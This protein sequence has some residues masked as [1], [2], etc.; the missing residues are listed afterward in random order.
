MRPLR[1]ASLVAAVGLLAACAEGPFIDRPLEGKV[2]KP[3]DA[4]IERGRVNV[5]YA[6][7]G[8]FAAAEKIAVDTCGAYGLQARLEFHDRYQCRLSTPHLAT[9]QCYDPDMTDRFGQYINP[10]NEQAVA[11]WRKRTGGKKGPTVP[12]AT[13]IPGVPSAGAT[14]TAPKPAEPTPVPPP[15]TA[16]PAPTPA[17]AP[18]APEPAPPAPPPPNID[19]GFT[20]HPGSWGDAFDQQ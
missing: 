20:L 14:A 3:S 19:G 17:P 8:E 13:I 12:R 7:A 6:S 2:R 4:I 16:A 5:C 10:F 15:P 1:F 18:A 11:E 9:F